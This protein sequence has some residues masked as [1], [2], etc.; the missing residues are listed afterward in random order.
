VKEANRRHARRLVAE[1]LVAYSAVRK[2]G[3]FMHRGMARTLDLSE[4][5]MRVETA[6]PL[7]LGE[8]LEFTLK[9]VDEVHVVQGQVR[10]GATLGVSRFEFGVH[11]DA[12]GFAL[13]RTVWRLL[14]AQ[15]EQTPRDV[16]HE[17]AQRLL[18]VLDEGDRGDEPQQV[19]ATFTI[20][21]EATISEAA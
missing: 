15:P 10:W 9:L 11:F 5:G 1:R 13:A 18:R 3:L 6:E 20:S 21:D 19:I 7:P 16:A 14:E 2:D 12:P 8:S 4:E 17:L